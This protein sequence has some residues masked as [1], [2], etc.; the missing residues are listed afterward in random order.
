MP[1]N[2]LVVEDDRVSRNLICEVLRNEGH[3][4]VEGSDGLKHWN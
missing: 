4:V 2:I 1:A 3:Q